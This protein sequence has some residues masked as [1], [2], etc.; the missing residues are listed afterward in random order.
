[1]TVP[2]PPRPCSDWI[3]SRLK[4]RKSNLMALVSTA[5]GVKSRL[6]PTRPSVVCV[7]PL[8]DPLE[9]KLCEV[10]AVTHTF[11]CT[12]SAL[13]SCPRAHAL[14]MCFAWDAPP[15]LSL[16]D[17]H[18]LMLVTQ[19]LSSSKPLLVTFHW[20][21][22]L[23]HSKALLSAPCSPALWSCLQ[24]GLITGFSPRHGTALSGSN[25]SFGGSTLPS[26]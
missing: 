9:L 5:P 1:M 24:P 25:H 18:L 21:T 14:A 13:S 12:R 11:L 4:R 6:F 8:S 19:R 2:D 15:G 22:R 3:Q 20:T 26:A 10:G 17:S 7:P 16:C 23:S